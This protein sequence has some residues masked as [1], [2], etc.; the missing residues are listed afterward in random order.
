[1]KAIDER[2]VSH[3]AILEPGKIDAEGIREQDQR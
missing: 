1:L 2:F 3:E